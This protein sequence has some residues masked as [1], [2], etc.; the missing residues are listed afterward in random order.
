MKSYM[1]ML[2]IVYFWYSEVGTSN[3]MDIQRPVCMI[4]CRKILRNSISIQTW[5][6]MNQIW[7][8]R[9]DAALMHTDGSNSAKCVNSY[10]NKITLFMISSHCFKTSDFSDKVRAWPSVTDHTDMHR[11]EQSCSI[12]SKYDSKG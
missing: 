6:G 3:W 2:I 4:L 10:A 11:M 1:K 5:Q 8:T 7:S 12:W 9:H